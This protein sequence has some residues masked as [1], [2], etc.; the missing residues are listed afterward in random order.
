MPD[1][2]VPIDGRTFT[3]SYTLFGETITVSS[4]LLGTKSAV[5]RSLPAPVLATFRRKIE[6]FQDCAR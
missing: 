2:S 3:G 1:V 5:V 6:C 4:D